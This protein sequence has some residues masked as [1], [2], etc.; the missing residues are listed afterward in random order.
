MM[1]SNRESTNVFLK[2]FT[3]DCMYFSSILSSY[4]YESFPEFPCN[5]KMLHNIDAGTFV[6]LI[7]KQ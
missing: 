6:L 4:S 5:N 2:V 3:N 1:N 7:S